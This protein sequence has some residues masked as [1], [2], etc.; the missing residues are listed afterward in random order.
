MISKMFG[1]EEKKLLRSSV[2]SKLI[3]LSEFTLMKGTRKDTP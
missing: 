3:R 1:S 2:M